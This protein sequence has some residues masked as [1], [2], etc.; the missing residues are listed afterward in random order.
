M[1]KMETD[2]I[3]DDPKTQVS[4]RSKRKCEKRSRKISGLAEF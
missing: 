4:L 1:M 2:K 3:A